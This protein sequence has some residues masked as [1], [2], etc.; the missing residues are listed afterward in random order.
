MTTEAII[1]TTHV[2]ALLGNNVCIWN[3][4]NVIFQFIINNQI[5][6]IPLH[7]PWTWTTTLHTLLETYF[8]TF[9]NKLNDLTNKKIMR[10]KITDH[11]QLYLGLII[12]KKIK[13]LISDI[14]SLYSD[15]DNHGDIVA[16]LI[17]GL[18]KNIPKKIKINDA[19]S[20]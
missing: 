2:D 9:K 19:I 15:D 7:D 16:Q 4:G 14:V 10:V 13:H 5:V 11:L 8:M 3:L 6:T 18:C 1:T 17:H 20:T 12:N